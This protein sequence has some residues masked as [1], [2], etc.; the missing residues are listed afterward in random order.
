[1]DEREELRVEGGTLMGFG[2]YYDLTY[3]QVYRQHS[4][5]FQWALDQEQNY[6]VSGPLADFLDWAKQWDQ[7]VHVSYDSD[8]SDAYDEY[9]DHFYEGEGGEASDDEEQVCSECG[10]VQHE[11]DLMARG[12][13]DRYGRCGLCTWRCDECEEAFDEDELT[14]HESGML[15]PDCLEAVQD[16]EEA[17]ADAGEVEVTGSRTRAERDAA[18]R[19]AAVDVDAEPETPTAMPPSVKQEVEPATPKRET[20]SGKQEIKGE[21]TGEV[22]D[23]VKGEEGTEPHTQTRKR[24]LTRN[25]SLSA[26]AEAPTGEAKRVKRELPLKQ[27]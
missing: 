10:A 11:F 21:A 1:M 9:V 23:E 16:E 13:L 19:L 17:A 12:P 5:Y 7:G 18:L 8:D 4:D 22:M 24:S 27:E 26:P 14:E 25:L 15:C 3:L 2:K 20:P 6:G